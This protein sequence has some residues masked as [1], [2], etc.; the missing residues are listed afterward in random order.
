MSKY[1]LIVEY[2]KG[3]ERT[4]DENHELALKFPDYDGS[5]IL[6]STQ[7]GKDEFIAF[8]SLSDLG[9]TFAVIQSYS[10]LNFAV[11]SNPKPDTQ[12]EARRAGFKTD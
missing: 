1:G 11:F 8:E 5:Y 10:Q 4:L 2:L 7:N 3:F 6:L 12:P 9:K